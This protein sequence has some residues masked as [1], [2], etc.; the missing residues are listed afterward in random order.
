[1][2]LEARMLGEPGPDRL[3]LVGRIVVE[4]EMQIEVGGRLAVDG[5]EKAR[6][7]LGPMAG[8]AFADDGTGLEVGHVLAGHH[9]G[10]KQRR[11]ARKRSSSRPLRL[12][13]CVMV[14]ARPFF[15]GRPGCVR[16]R[17]WIWLFSS[18]DST[19][20]LAGGSR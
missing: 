1:M 18:T 7:L 11:G 10:R 9:E 4:D 19:M 6:E 5:F 15:R 16:S 2:Q 13:S 20:A 17:A 12:S 8:E 3:G 14:A